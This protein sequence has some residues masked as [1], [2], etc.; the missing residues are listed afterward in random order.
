M[1]YSS[2]D[3]TRLL[4][5]YAQDLDAPTTDFDG[6]FRIEKKYNVKPNLETLKIKGGKV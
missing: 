5:D 3:K 1:Y 6:D 4:K 2:D